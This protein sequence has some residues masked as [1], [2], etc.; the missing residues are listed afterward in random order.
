MYFFSDTN[1]NKVAFREFCIFSEILK[2]EH[3]VNSC[4]EYFWVFI[5]LSSECPIFLKPVFSA[6]IPIS[7]NR[8]L[9]IESTKLMTI[10]GAKMEKNGRK[11][12][13]LCIYVDYLPLSGLESEYELIRLQS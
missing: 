8:K 11:N 10:F 5:N 1:L 2:K 13:P 12:A 7:T 4:L 9:C 6:E 3:G